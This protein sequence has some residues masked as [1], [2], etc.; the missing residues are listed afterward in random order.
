MM[1]GLVNTCVEEMTVRLTLTYRF[2]S[3]DV[4]VRLTERG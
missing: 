3:D 2:V 4:Y 1:G